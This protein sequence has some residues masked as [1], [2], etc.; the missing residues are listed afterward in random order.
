MEMEV[1]KKANPAPLGLLGFGMTT[2]LLNLANAG[3]I[4]LNIV[5]IAMGIALGGLAQI[6]AGI[7]E[8]HNDNTFGETAFIAYGLFWGH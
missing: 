6:F 8:Y 1:Q 3:I 2:I 7:L 4:E 5:I